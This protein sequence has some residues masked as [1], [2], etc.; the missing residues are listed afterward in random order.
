VITA[1][2]LVGCGETYVDESLI[3]PT[4][5]APDQ[6]TAEADGA[7]G[8]DTDAAPDD[9]ATALSR[10]DDA[11]DRLS[12]AV[13]DDP[14]LAGELL[15][16]IDSAWASVEDG[17]RAEHP[18]QLFG[19]QQAIDLAHSAVTRK[20]PADASKAWKILRDVAPTLG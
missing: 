9:L 1:V 5:T 11:L 2:A 16:T 8:A 15:A 18:D 17:V 10:I 13:A 19:I 14:E 4:T 3:D 7:D 12:D 6:T 20:R